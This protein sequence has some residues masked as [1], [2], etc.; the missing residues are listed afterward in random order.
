ML[1]YLNIR[2]LTREEWTREYILCS[3]SYMRSHYGLYPQILTI[4]REYRQGFPDG[5]GTVIHCQVWWLL[6]FGPEQPHGRKIELTSTNG[7]T[8]THAWIC[9]HTLIKLI[10]FVKSHIAIIYTS[11]SSASV[12]FEGG[13][14]QDWEAGRRLFNC[15]GVRGFG[16]QFPLKC[17]VFWGIK[18][19]FSS[20]LSGVSVVLPLLRH[21]SSEL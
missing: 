11:T 8:F 5:S 20:S 17:I 13:D 9:T 6:E 7:R 2:L 14:I 19:P 16:Y 1:T 10:N 21:E 4:G 18:S 12:L 3:C 15:L